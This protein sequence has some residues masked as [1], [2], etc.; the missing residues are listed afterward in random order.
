MPWTTAA[1]P[2][3]LR[4]PSNTPP[5]LPAEP[6]LAFLLSKLLPLAVYPLGLAL[7]LHLAALLGHRRRWAP[8]LSSAGLALLWLAATPLV[9][10]ELLWGL[11]EQATRLTPRTLPRADAVLVLGGGLRPALAPRRRVELA[12]AGDRLLTGIDLLRQGLAPVLV[13]SGGRVSFTSSDPAPPEM[14]AAARLAQELGVP[15]GRILRNAGLEP[16]GPRT[17]AEEAQAIARLAKQQ[18]WRSLLLVT[19]ATH[20]PRALASFQRHLPADSGVR[21]IPVAC[22]YQLPQRDQIGRTTAAS[23][24]LSL[25]PNADSLASTT[26]ALKE[27]I[28]LQV[29]RLRG[30]AR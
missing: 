20:L 29:Y 17:T 21:L 7:L 25:L 27:H 10:R 16:D 26:A 24:V 14:D 23:A 19:S 18:G 3:S 15:A 11:E 1:M 22:D 9:S 13:V 30:W 2:P 8:W 28:G 5:P 4:S 12:E 6:P